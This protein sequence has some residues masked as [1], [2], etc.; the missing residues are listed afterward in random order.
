ML[1]E[2]RACST[3]DRTLKDSLLFLTSV[4][5]YH[6]GKPAIVLIDEYDAPVA[7]AADNGYYDEMVDFMR[8][9]LLAGLK[10]NLDNLMFGILTGCLR[11]TRESI[12]SGLNHLDCFDITTDHKYADTF[13][14]T[15]GEVD[16][17]LR[18]TG[19]WE[20]RDVL[21]TWYDGYRF[22][23]LTEIYCPWS[24]MK[25]LRDL[26]DNPGSDPVAYWQ[27][28][29]ENALVKRLFPGTT[30]EMTQ[31]IADFIEGGCLVKQLR[32]N[33]TYE[34]LDSSP[35]NLWTL[36]YMSGYL[37]RASKERAEAQ[38]LA[39]NP[40]DNK[41]PL[42]IPNREIRD[43]FRYEVSTWFRAAV[44]V[45]QENAFFAAFW[46]ADAQAVQQELEAILL[47]KVGSQ[48][49][50]KES[51]KSPREN[52]YHG[53]L[54]GFFL[55]AYPK[56]FSNLHAGTGQ[57]DISVLDD[58]D[59]ASK[60]AAIVEIKR[61]T[62]ENEDLAVLAE[63]GLTQIRERKYDVRLL[64]DPT[65]TTVLHWSIAFFKKSCEARAVLVRQPQDHSS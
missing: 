23:N 8:S 1:R 24:I 27:N 46:Q 5:R 11:I 37:T 47:E 3:D 34:S 21:K 29:S 61:A 38:G 43:I 41:Y 25:Y 52:F 57:Y 20:K 54:I 17:L 64:A 62:S 63:K 12:F 31:D 51:P 39:P 2:L 9:F 16:T 45:A 48:D 14:F 28:T 32:V 35:D 7:K 33:P 58:A 36:L 50:A 18:D 22:G 65:V 30:V 53:L 13:G 44:S 40:E 60:R 59:T 55:V 15:Q 42:V 19:F 4:L 6:S 56:T 49:L 26:Q 10:T